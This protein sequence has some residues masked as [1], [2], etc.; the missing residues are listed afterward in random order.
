M[1]IVDP[2]KKRFSSFDQIKNGVLRQILLLSVLVEQSLSNSTRFASKSGATHAKT[3]Y[4]CNTSKDVEEIP[5]QLLA[6]KVGVP[7]VPVKAPGDE[8]PS[9]VFGLAI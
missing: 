8:S 3:A 6:G 7:G 1:R 9:Q 4:R 2:C 5:I